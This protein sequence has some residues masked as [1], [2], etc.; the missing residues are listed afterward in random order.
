MAATAYWSFPP[1]LEVVLAAAERRPSDA[2][3]RAAFE[4]RLNRRP[5]PSSSSSQQPEGATVVGPG[6]SPPPVAALDPCL[7][8]D[9]LV[10]PATLYLLEVR[11]RLTPP[12]LRVLK[13]SPPR[14]LRRGSREGTCA[15]PAC[16]P[17]RR[18][19]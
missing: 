12:A 10:A 5:I 9:D 16:R 6:G 19:I 15:L 17:E 11:Q 18:S 3:A 4:K 8:V 7:I 2:Q 1:N 14:G 13:H